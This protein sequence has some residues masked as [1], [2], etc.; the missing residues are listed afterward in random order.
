MT[1]RRIFLLGGSAA[2]IGVGGYLALDDTGARA[3]DGFEV[4]LTDAQWRAR[5]TA[6]EFA[7]LRQ[8]AT[9]PAYSSPLNDENRDGTFVCA[10]CANAIYSSATKYESGTGWPSFWTNIDGRVGTKTDYKLIFPRTEV[11]CGRCGGHLGHIFD[12][13]PAPTGKRHCL[14]G[15]ALDFVAA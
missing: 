6:N 3:D 5:L 9:E 15:L 10:G 8:E 1:S 11:H 12:D 2:A 13:G 14:N 4:D 7:V